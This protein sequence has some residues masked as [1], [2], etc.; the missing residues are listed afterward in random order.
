MPCH[1]PI[2]QT[3]NYTGRHTSKAARVEPIAAENQILTTQQFAALA[4]CTPTR[5]I[6]LAY[7]GDLALPKNYGTERLYLLTATDLDMT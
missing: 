6:E 3:T 5:S 1:D 4:A 7:V 2:N